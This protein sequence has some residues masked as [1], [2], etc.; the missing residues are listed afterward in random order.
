LLALTLLLPV[1]HY[2]YYRSHWHPGQYPPT[3]PTLAQLGRLLSGLL[4]AI[5]LD[6]LGVGLGLA[7]LAVWRGRA[8][9]KPQAAYGV[10]WAA[11]ALL[12]V[13]GLC[14]YLP[15]PALSGRYTMPAVWGVDLMLAALVSGLAAVPAAAWRRAA[16]TGLVGGLAAVAAA[17]VGRQEKFAARAAVLWDT[18][19]YVERTAPPEEHVAW[20]SGPGL[21]V[22]EGIHFRWHLL[23][24]GR[25]DVAVE[26]YD[27]R[28]RPEERCELPMARGAAGLAVTGTP[29][30]PAAGGPWVLRGQFRRPYWA[31]RKTYD[32]Y[33][34]AAATDLTQRLRVLATP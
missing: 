29:E 18:L 19:E 3:G 12:A 11:G 31:G 26:L 14:V 34:W 30:P 17:N 24:R 33:L 32:C 6:F 16:W 10:V 2:V 28:G 20:L 8:G 9:A 23:A 1:A 27:E 7:G 5:R 25:D 15:I 22:E 21:N 13:C 4:G